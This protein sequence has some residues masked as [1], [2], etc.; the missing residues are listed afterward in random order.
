M[1]KTVERTLEAFAIHGHRGAG[2]PFSY[3]EIYELVAAMDPQSRSVEVKGRVFVLSTFDVVDGRV[4][5]ISHEGDADA[6]PLYYDRE[7]NK[8]RIGRK[9]RTEIVSTRAHALI[10]IEKRIAVVEYNQ[11]GA[12]ASHIASI[13]SR[14]AHEVTRDYGIELDLNPLPGQSF[15]DEMELIS[16]IRSAEVRV[17]EPNVS[18]HEANVRVAQASDARTFALKLFARRSSGLSTSNG[19]I[20]A[21]RQM[22]KRP[23]P[24]LKEATIEGV[25]SEGRS[26]TVRLKSHVTKD[27]FELTVDKKDGLPKTS[28]VLDA[29]SRFLNYAV[30]ESDRRRDQQD[31]YFEDIEI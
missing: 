20:P 15:N 12:K 3:K 1:R 31:D 18:W 4:V 23:L 24:N 2:E 7:T 8:E 14:L 21:I 29:L 19:L 22:L 5:I 9:G 6:V 16:R 28:S 11:R 26:K 27:K 25:T 10:D 17:F 13:I 30:M